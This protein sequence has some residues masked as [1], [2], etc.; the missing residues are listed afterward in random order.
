MG[1]AVLPVCLS[2]WTLS[3]VPEEDRKEHK[4]PRTGITAAVS[5]H[6]VLGIE[7]GPSEEQ[8]VLLTTGHLSDY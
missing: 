4:F 8:L 1:K 5:H 7:L 2:A 6:V 3:A